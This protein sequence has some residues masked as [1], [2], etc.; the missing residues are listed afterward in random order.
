MWSE[1]LADSII[2]ASDSHLGIANIYEYRMWGYT[3]NIL[4]E[5]PEI[6]TV[7]YY[8]SYACLGHNG[9]PQYE[10]PDFIY[11][12]LEGFGACTIPN[13]SGL[14]TCSVSKVLSA[15]E[16]E[17]KYTHSVFYYDD[18]NRVIQSNS[19]THL[20]GVIEKAYMT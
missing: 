4:L 6:F 14:L 16:S 19:S 9:L 5:T 12:K 3:M 17:N 2:Y 15:D 13:F 10:D 7:N 8:D 11:D 1:P 20:D 18:K